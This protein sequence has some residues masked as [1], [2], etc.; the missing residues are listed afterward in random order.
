MALA[1]NKDTIESREVWRT[2]RYTTAAYAQSDASANPCISA[3]EF[4]VLNPLQRG[5]E[6]TF[7]LENSEQ[8]H[9]HGWSK[10]ASIGVSH[11]YFR[12][13]SSCIRIFPVI[14]TGTA[15]PSGSKRRA[16][17]ERIARLVLLADSDGA[18]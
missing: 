10:S 4:A 13:Q 15:H 17:N 11:P 1:A 12:S 9:S 6:I 16:K 5:I 2:R 3:A 7:S 18:V 14:V 8:Y